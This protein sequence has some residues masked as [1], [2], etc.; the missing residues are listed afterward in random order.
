MDFHLGVLPDRLAERYGDRPCMQVQRDGA[1]RRFSYREFANIVRS[2]AARLDACGL[3]GGDRIALVGENSPEWLLAY[4]AIMAVGAVAVPLDPQLSAEELGHLIAH[5][6]ARGAFST[7]HARKAVEQA[8]HYDRPIIPLVPA[9]FDSGTPAPGPD[10]AGAGQPAP[11]LEPWGAACAA[12]ADRAASIL[13]TSGTTGTPKGVVLTHRNF[14]FDGQGAAEHI[15]VFPDDNSF[16]LLPLH[17]AYSFTCTLVALLSG[18]VVTLPTSLR[19]DAVRTAMRETRV[20]ILPAVPLLM[21]HLVRGIRE[22]IAAQPPAR[23]AVARFLVALAGRLRPVIGATAARRIAR[24]VLAQ[25]G[26][27]RL[28]IAGGAALSE[29]S[30]EFFHRLGVTVLHGYGLT[31][32]APVISF[33][34][35]P[36]RP[37]DGVGKPL[38]GVEV[39]IATPNAEGIGEILVR[40]DC[41]MAGYDRAP[42]ETSAVL[43]DGWLNTQDL[44][45]LDGRGYLHLFGRSKH[46]IV[47]KSGK[48]VYPEDLEAVAGRSPLIREICVIA[49]TEPDGAEFP[50]GIIVPDPDKLPPTVPR[51]EARSRIADELARLSRGLPLHRRLARFDLVEGPLPLTTARKIRRHLVQAAYRFEAGEAVRVMAIPRPA[52][53]ADLKLPRTNRLA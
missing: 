37:E 26:R 41:V 8:F 28:I 48:N 32:T 45:K 24:P 12:S 27:L 14:L 39:R 9:E 2:M 7:I 31:E 46:V 42:E 4:F 49:G 15:Y 1:L 19:Q 29:D 23:R 36:W 35:G 18:V 5:S 17:H 50:F 21:D 16:S 33:T 3:R 51:D 22:G 6:E 20:T 53:T 52:L 38:R 10:R 44:G 40:G 13:Y 11:D 30:A 47:L 25:L 34:P 43:R